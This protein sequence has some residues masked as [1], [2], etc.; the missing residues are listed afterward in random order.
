MVGAYS[1]PI[2]PIGFDENVEVLEHI[3]ALN[4]NFIWVGLSTPKQEV[5]MHM[6]MP[7]IGRGVALGPRAGYSALRL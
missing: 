2:R 4:P 5:W 1:P 6:H 7:K 3:R